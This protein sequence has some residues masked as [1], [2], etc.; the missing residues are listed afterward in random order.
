MTDQSSNVSRNLD[1]SFVAATSTPSFTVNSPGN[2]GTTTVPVGS[3]NNGMVL[4][5]SNHVQ[6]RQVHTITQANMSYKLFAQ[7]GELAKPGQTLD[8]YCDS[9]A[10]HQIKIYLET[11]KEVDPSFA[12]DMS[13][14]IKDIIYAMMQYHHKETKNMTAIEFADKFTYEHDRDPK[15][16]LIEAEPAMKAYEKNLLA[17]T[18]LVDN[19]PT[20]MTETEV[21]AIITKLIKN[22]TKSVA[23]QGQT[24]PAVKTI[25]TKLETLHNQNQI[26]TIPRYQ[27]KFTHLRLELIKAN[28]EVR[29]TGRLSDKRKSQY[30][31]DG[32]TREYKRG[33]GNQQGRGR[34]QTTRK[35]CYICNGGPH[36]EMTCW[37]Y[38]H[39]D[40]NHER[41]PFEQS[42][43]GAEWAAQGYERLPNNI[44]LDGTPWV[45]PQQPQQ[46]Q[47]SYGGR[48]Y[49]P[50]RG[51]G[52]FQN[53]GRG[54]R[55]GG[56][57][58]QSYQ[59]E[60]LNT[61]NDNDN[62][63]KRKTIQRC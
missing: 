43:K 58:N 14:D 40:G 41:K 56:R 1:S 48:G 4:Q 5:V 32:R 2:F 50:Y 52:R 26:R 49:S 39:P 16:T 15:N 46:Q 47:V 29:E 34:F 31:Y 17:L 28:D 42:A 22:L 21:N 51:G 8:T 11:M 63:N 19:A 60:F 35:S 23:V 54:G 20:Q 18:K 12:I 61:T 24:I 62:N 37:L 3:N 6:S 9:D 53:R 33:R 10:I 44:K 27:V 55:F 36:S 13:S 25:K 38:E 59:S 45:N 30:D 57:T 7:A